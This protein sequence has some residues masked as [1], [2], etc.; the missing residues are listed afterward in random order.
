METNELKQLYHYKVSIYKKGEV[1]PWYRNQS[2]DEFINEV[3]DILDQ[4]DTFIVLKDWYFTKLYKEKN[5]Y[6]TCLNKISLY[7]RTRD[8]ILDNGV[9]YTLYSDKPKTAKSIKKEIQAFIQ[10]EF[11]WLSEGI[12]LSII[13]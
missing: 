1:L 7:A 8:T 4:N 3:I 2:K 6:S 10:K 12:D 11:G 9:F 13:K 5:T